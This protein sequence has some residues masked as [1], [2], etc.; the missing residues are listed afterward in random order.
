MFVRETVMMMD[1]MMRMAVMCMVLH[2]HI[3]EISA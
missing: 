1:M 2:A 3:E